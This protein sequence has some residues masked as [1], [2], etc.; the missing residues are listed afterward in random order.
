MGQYYKPT[1]LSED[2]KVEAWAYSHDFKEKYTRDDGTSFTSGTGLKLMEHSWIGNGFV[3][4]IVA[5]LIPTGKFYKHRLVWAGDYAD[6]EPDMH[7]SYKHRRLDDESEEAYQDRIVECSA[8][9]NLYDLCFD[10]TKVKLPK[11]K[12]HLT[13]P[14]LV[15]YSSKSYV[16]LRKVPG[17]DGEWADW[18]IHPLPL[19]TC[20]GNGGGGGDFYGGDPELLLGKWARDVIGVERK[21]PDGNFFEL[22]FD[23]KE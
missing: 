3:N 19:L 20:E 23:L 4:G 6:P 7:G 11:R 12:V 1:I 18:R 17:G 21:V 13:H 5:L 15:N 9:A 8:C 16:D 10:E 14:I 2:N 22:L